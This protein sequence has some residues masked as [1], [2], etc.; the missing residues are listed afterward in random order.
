MTP[1]PKL[2]RPRIDMGVDQETW[3]TFV[4]RWETF[5]KGSHISAEYQPTQLFQ[6]ASESLGD[7]LLK[8]NPDIM[9]KPVKDVLEAM[10][11]LAV[12]PVAKGVIRAELMQLGQGND[13][14][15]RTFAARVKGKA[16]TCGYMTT[17]KCTCDRTVTA[18]YTDEIIRDVLLAGISDMDIRRE[19]LGMGDILSKP[20]N[21]V[22]SFVEGREMARNA[23]PI[24]SLASVS[25]F[26]R[27]KVSQGKPQV[28]TPD[29]TKTAACPD[30]G[31]TYHL[32]RERPSGWNAKPFTKCI[33]CWRANMK[34][35]RQPPLSDKSPS[36]PNGECAVL[37]AAP[38]DNISQISALGT[39]DKV[40]LQHQIFDKGTWRRARFTDHPRA[41]FELSRA[42]LDQSSH[43]EQPVIV[44]GIAD[45]GAQSNL[46]GLRNFL[47]AGYSLDDL[48]PVSLNIRAANKN[49][50]NVVGA[51]RGRF[52]GRSANG[53]TISSQAMVYVSDSVVGFYLSYD[54]MVDLLMINRDFPRIG[55]CAEN[56]ADSS[57]VETCQANSNIDGYVRELNAGCA[58]P[59]GE[60]APCDCPQR[61][62]V[63]DRPKSLPFSPI[64][65]N[66]EKMREW[67]LHRYASSTFNTC[68]HRPLP[69]MSGPPVE[70]HID[71]SCTPRTCHTAAP[72]PMH[73]QKRVYEDLLRDEA[74][75]VIER[76]PYGVPV[77][78][79]HRMVVTRKH[80]G[81]PRRTVDLSPLNKF[82]KRE[83][84]ASEA[85]FQLARR[86]P[87]NTWKTVTDAWNG[88]H[89]VPL[90]ESDRHLTTFITPFGRWR[91]TRAP[92]GFLSSG[93]GYNRRFDEILSEFQRKE[94]CVDDTIYYDDDL[95]S[96]WWRTIDF[97]TIT[98]S[99]GIVLNPD[100]FQF[101]QRDVDFAGF[102]MSDTSIEPLPR[103]IDAIKSF[104]TPTSTTDIKSWFGLVNQVSNYAQ[105][106]D[107]MAI[108][109]PFLSPKYK[110]FWTPV[111]DKAFN[112]SKKAI[113]EAIKTGVEIFDMTKP[114]CLRPD[115][116][117]RGIG[118]FLL[119]QHCT[120]STGM[121]DCCPNGWRV[122]LAGSRFLS[123]AEQR[124]A[125]I[126]G[127][128]L[129]IAWGLEQTRYFTQGCP[130]LLVVTDHKPLTKIFGDRT[131]DEISNTRLFRLKQRTLPWHFRTTYLPGKTNHAADATS[132]HPSPYTEVAASSV[133]D[134]S[135][136]C[137]AAS[138]TREA[139]QV[140]TIPWSL[141]AS[142]TQK[143]PV[144][145]DLLCAISEEFKHDYPSVSSYMRYRDSLYITNGVILY[146]DRVVVPTS[147]RQ[148]VLEGLHAA[149]QGV[150][151]MELRAQS[152]VFWPGMTDDI[153]SIRSGCRECN[154]NAPSQAP[155]PS[156]PAVPP[157]TP[158]EQVFADF[159]EFGGHH[160]LVIGDRLSGWSEIFSTPSGSSLSGARG[161]ISCLRSFFSTFGV[162]EELASDGGPEFKA[163]ATA[164]FLHRWGVKHRISS[165]YHPQSNG[166]AEVAVKSAKRLLRSN[167]GTTGSLDNDRL[168]RALLQLRNTP[169]PDCNVSPAQIIF[170]RPIRDAF[171]FVNRLEKFSNPHVRPA[172]RDAWSSKETALRTRFTRS[173]ES[174]NEH[175]RSLPPLD[176]GDRCFIQNQTGNQPNKWHRSGVVTEV[177]P[178]DQY[179]MK[180]DGSGRVTR[181]N[182]R[183]LRSY[184]SATSDIER[185]PPPSAQ[186]SCTPATPLV[187]SPVPTAAQ[188]PPV[189]P[190]RPGL[191]PRRIP[192][193][194][195][196]PVPD[197]PVSC[198]PEEIPL[199]NSSSPAP[200]PAVQTART[201]AA[202]KRLLPHNAAGLKEAPLASEDGGRRRRST[203]NLGGM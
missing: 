64:A 52:K 119:Q 18:D 83:T 23:T 53:D 13:E 192:E 73:W 110:F 93:D 147:L 5:H 121:P 40:I 100:K 90:R 87:G 150:S 160:Y 33:D 77:T 168:L 36:P 175:V 10:K 133:E 27:T 71:E 191:L 165:A 38:V 137:I 132:R 106:R 31:K 155:L 122:T 115:W 68:P 51:F 67:L 12:I 101:A 198:A 113:I 196:L 123:G 200:R 170:G 102:H 78:W 16:A 81:T 190:Q 79:C 91:Y 134:F 108:F 47:E 103:Y 97:L 156:E 9:S 112:D 161:L 111:L 188:C 173:S 75:G 157:S 11:S 80:D 185:A 154:R 89:S 203:M 24:S 149:H 107:V 14:Q 4:R 76:V 66:N 39:S 120:C 187:R 35:R 48:R 6:C 49:P 152:I 142:E 125:A 74:L 171:S 19:A 169:D 163:D 65:E 182:R 136:S 58:D 197:T 139:E 193:N 46:W 20:V 195:D 129:A 86:V 57:P 135:E 70:I 174:L 55:S 8:T 62:S 177:L 54:T 151:S 7:T 109:R 148:S 186:L 99:S 126:E 189:T 178:H 30:C 138:V 1:G 199:T 41:R 95:E 130:N 98:G 167:V 180:V 153:H 176:V 88:F 201:P 63:P 28:A 172:W 114:T 92:Q 37:D 116:S 59:H 26:K 127:E 2:D 17:V 43:V 128:A 96:H 60:T 124:Y 145:S 69:C 162:P 72:V 85:P 29:R 117:S 159:F 194:F 21:E 3:D 184:K 56:S 105:L 34:R 45:T 94:R 166:R 140:T 131:L 143:D 183:F 50:I 141:L 84:F 61:S 22:I 164:E 15:F 42:D 104:P 202:L 82:C 158:F 146:K 118:Y 144:L 32:Y 179:L 181:R 25:T 44:D